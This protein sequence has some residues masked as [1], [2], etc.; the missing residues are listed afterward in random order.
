[1]TRSLRLAFVLGVLGLASA[2]KSMGQGAPA[3]T[4]GAIPDTTVAPAP[5]PSPSPMLP[6]PENAPPDTGLGGFLRGLADSTDIYFGPSSAPVDTVGL[7]STL[8]FR[9]ANPDAFSDMRRARRASWGPW[10]SFNR[11]DGPLY[12][13]VLTLGR[14]ERH[15]AISGRAGYAVG[16]NDWLSGL[17]YRKRWV[18]KSEGEG[19]EFRRRR[20]GEN[21]WT[22][23]VTGGEFTS[24]IDPDGSMS[25]Q[26]VLR[27]L[28]NGS[29]RHHYYRREGYLLRLERES[30]RSRVAVQFRDQVESPLVTTTTW[31]FL[32]NEPEIPFNLPAA[33]GRV[34]ETE[35]EAT[36]RIPRT[37]WQAEAHVRLAGQ[38]LASD[39]DYQR[40]S[41]ATGGDVGLGHFATL[42]PQ[43]VY[44]RL[45]GDV[46]PQAAFYFGGPHSLRSIPT[47]SFAGTRKAFG[48][49]DLIF[50]P[51]LGRFLHLPIPAPIVVQG[52]V[53]T[54]AGSVWGPDPYGGSAVEG[55]E[56]FPEEWLS[57]VG[58][59]LL[60]RPGLPEPRGFL[61]LDYARGVG[62]NPES[63][64]TV[65][66]SVPLDL[67]HRLE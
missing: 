28:V 21:A 3:D 25:W 13:A 18:T 64:V 27:A 57:E 35:F 56:A 61:R 14:A 42:V 50:T 60:Y 39:F 23:E 5:T 1:M 9:L 24:V 16:P 26:R 20:Q 30:A 37:G 51:D 32:S 62:N 49:L 66:Y 19:A 59:S 29:D 15:G 44:G 38:A 11:V 2:A 7:D 54:G 52:G 31:N 55:D 67:L 40:Y 48:K 17:S 46:I 12:G 47:N 10:F 22:L 4:V 34:R 33:D 8:A 63:K 43:F 6:P 41:F 45:E 53:F 36:V 65:H 58:V